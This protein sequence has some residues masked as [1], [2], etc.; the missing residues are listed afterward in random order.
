[1]KHRSV[2]LAALGLGILL[3]VSAP[4][5]A[6]RAGGGHGGGWHGGGWGHAG[7]ARGPGWGWR[8]GPYWWGPRVAYGPYP[9]YYPYYAPGL[10]VTIP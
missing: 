1:M 5:F 10:T 9:Y 7:W 2:L 3:S 4:A 8:G 6:Q